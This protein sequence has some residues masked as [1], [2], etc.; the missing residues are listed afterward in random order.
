MSIISNDFGR[1]LAQVRNAVSSMS[2]EMQSMRLEI[3]QLR[4][5]VDHAYETSVDNINATVLRAAASG[6]QE[7]LQSLQHQALTPRQAEMV[8]LSIQ[9]EADIAP[10]FE[11]DPV[12][13][14]RFQA[15]A[16]AGQGL[17][18]PSVPQA[19][20]NNRAQRMHELSEQLRYNAAQASEDTQI[21]QQMQRR[22]QNIE[23]DRTKRSR[24]AIGSVVSRSDV[25][26]IEDY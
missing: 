18:A 21:R 25:F 5:E 12:M 4:K 17:P 22:I 23:Q 7:Q 26:D 14:A 15:A 3:E 6:N 16:N 24:N 8:R 9:P 10:T 13:I 20:V 2:A 19:P 11:L 1:A